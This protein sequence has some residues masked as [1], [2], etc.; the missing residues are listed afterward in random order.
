MVKIFDVAEAVINEACKKFGETFVINAENYEIFKG[1]CEALDTTLKEFSASTFS[2]DVDETTKEIEI[3]FNCEEIII[4]DKKH[5]F[6][7]LISRAVS[8]SVCT[9][10]A[11]VLIVYFK[12][13]SLWDKAE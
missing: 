3:V 6:Y 1:Y 12:F 11:D 5:I 13:P 2:V 4:D 10:S 7:E 9:P 8:F